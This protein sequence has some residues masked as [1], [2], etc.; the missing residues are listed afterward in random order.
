[1]VVVGA[2]VGVTVVVGAGDSVVV[3]IGPAVVVGAGPA[4]VDGTGDAQA[5]RMVIKPAMTATRR[6][7][8]GIRFTV[9]SF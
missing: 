8:R 6:A 7:W 9:S 2:V 3:G 1:M 5:A 4:V